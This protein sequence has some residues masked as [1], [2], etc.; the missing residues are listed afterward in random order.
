MVDY[1]PL[2]PKNAQMAG[3]WRKKLKWQK[4][5]FY[6]IPIYRYKVPK[7]R[8]IGRY[9]ASRPP[10]EAPIQGTPYQAITRVPPY[11]AITRVPHRSPHPGYPHI[12]LLPGTP[13][14]APIQGTPLSGYYQGTPIEAPIEGPR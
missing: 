11:Q 3:K 8:D 2:C 6:G 14:E 9:T 7:T 1:P 13:I 12:R 4:G 10:I 5:G